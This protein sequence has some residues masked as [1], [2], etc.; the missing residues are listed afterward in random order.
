MANKTSKSYVTQT[1]SLYLTAAEL[2]RRGFI[3]AVISRNAPG[4]DLLAQTPDMRRSYGV[5]GKGNHW[6]GTQS[7]LLTG[8]RARSDS[9][10]GLFYVFVNLKAGN[11]R[12]AFY[13]R[14]SSL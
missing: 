7:Y 13:V 10:P 8:R 14:P 5:Q 11:D 12:P 2:A 4:V 3:V 1:T 9:G 6:E